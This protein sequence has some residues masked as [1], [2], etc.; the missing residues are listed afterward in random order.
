MVA[1]N[2]KFYLY[3]AAGEL[4]GAPNGRPCFGIGG[5]R[6]QERAFKNSADGGT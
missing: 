4:V 5:G 1:E 3:P 6:G 2:G